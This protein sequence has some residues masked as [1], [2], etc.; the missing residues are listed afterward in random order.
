MEKLKKV[1]NAIGN[2]FAFL[3]RFVAN[4]LVLILLAI[5]VVAIIESADRPSVPGQAILRLNPSGNLVEATTEISG[6]ASLLVGDLLAEEV[7]VSSLVDAIESATHDSR[8]SMIELDLENLWGANLLQIEAIGEAL[9]EFK[10]AGKRIVAY[11]TSLSQSQYVLSS[12]A[13]EVYLHPMGQLLFPGFSMVRSYYKD[14]MDKLQLQMHVFSVGSFKTAVEPFT[15]SSMSDEARESYR[16]IV[17]QNW[18]ELRGIV[19][20]NTAVAPE[21]FDD[22]VFQLKQLLEAED[23]SIGSLAVS[24]GLIDGL[25][26][27][28]EYETHIE[29]IYEELTGR[30]EVKRITFNSYADLMEKKS[31]RI[32]PNSIGYIVAQGG[33]VTGSSNTMVIGS[34]WLKGAIKE[35]REED[36]IKALVLRVDSPGGS[37]FAS[38]Q[39]RLELQKFKESEKPLVVSMAGTAASGG[40]WIATP[41]DLIVAGDTTLTGSI[42]V[43]SMLPNV[44][45]TLATVG[46]NSDSL[47]TT[48]LGHYDDPTLPLSPQMAAVIQNSVDEVYKQFISIV[49][50]GRNQPIEHIERVAQG[51]VWTGVDA[52]NHGLVDMIGDF[53]D[54][55]EQAAELAGIAN[56]NLYRVKGNPKQGMPS[57]MSLILKSASATVPFNQILPSNSGTLGLPHSIRDPL[58]VYALC[59]SCEISTL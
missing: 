39:I 44:E 52:L 28:I 45:K 4:I 18:G 48:P 19:L 29:G 33:I 34:K 53:D 25:K 9:E 27:S 23:A 5:V 30:E 41:A 42:G 36:R 57:L 59:R 12:Y 8:I 54:A 55:I 11:G 20:A 26:D 15:R 40:Y 10:A 1:L 31:L 37:A 35:A 22:Y 32:K 56:Y 7:A 50:D 46:V 58:N 17:D 38:E 24:Q 43:F 2:I 49:S 47:T 16:P 21:Q 14:L 13:D 6:P 3:R 51:R